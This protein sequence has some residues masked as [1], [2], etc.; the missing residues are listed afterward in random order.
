MKLNL[1]VSEEAKL[2]DA[3]VELSRPKMGEMQQP[4]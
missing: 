2:L 3:V 1:S 4:I